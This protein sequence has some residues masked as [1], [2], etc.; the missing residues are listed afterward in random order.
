MKNVKRMLSAL[1][2][3]L[4]LATLVPAMAFAETAEAEGGTGETAGLIDSVTGLEIPTY[5]V[6][7]KLSNNLPASYAKITL[8]NQL[9]GETKTYNAN[10]IGLALIPKSLLG[11]YNVSATCAKNGVNYKT[12]PGLKWTMSILPEFETLVLYPSLDIGLNYSDHFSYMIG[13]NDGTIRPNNTIT[14][15]EAASMIFRLLTP[16]ARD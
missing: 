9:T 13:Y 5:A 10:G 8:T 15:G 16:E 7:C 2:V 14:R 4:M 3:V 11:V 12:L 1:L 6:Y